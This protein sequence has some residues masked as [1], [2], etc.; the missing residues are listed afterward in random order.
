MN[1]TDDYEKLMVLLHDLGS[2]TVEQVCANLGWD[3]LKA[4]SA[5][6]DLILSD[7]VKADDVRVKPTKKERRYS[8]R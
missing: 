4:K 6:M 5:L 2:A 1:T 7:R 8:L 3:G